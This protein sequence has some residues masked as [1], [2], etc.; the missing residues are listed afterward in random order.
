MSKHRLGVNSLLDKHYY[1]G[2]G[3]DNSVFY[4]A[5]RNVFAQLRYKF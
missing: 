4:G 3:N 2:M 5:P 1:S